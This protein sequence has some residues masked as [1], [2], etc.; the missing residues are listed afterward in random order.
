[1]MRK[2]VIFLFIGLAIFTGSIIFGS[3]YFPINKVS[4][5]SIIDLKPNN[6][7][8]F[9]DFIR[10]DINTLNNYHERW[11]TLH[12]L[13]N[14][15]KY[16]FTTIASSILGSSYKSTNLCDA[17]AETAWVPKSKGG[18]G[19]W[20]KITINA[21]SALSEYT[22]TPFSIFKIGILPGYAKSQ[23][24]WSENNRVKKL[25]VIIHSPQLSAPE[26]NEWVAFRLNLLDE[27]KVQVFNIPD[28][29][30]GYNFNGMKKEIW[31]KIEEIYKGTKY[32]DTCISEFIAVGGFTN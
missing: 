12:P 31:I 9:N 20:V 25:L 21:E 18:I 27:I 16:N 15:N 29:K 22:S 13:K 26:E 14:L 23:K 7:V 3:E 19:E 17:K 8:F 10:E 2:A 5:N 24:T 30:I 4:K 6:N 11:S 28:D 1:M 32:D